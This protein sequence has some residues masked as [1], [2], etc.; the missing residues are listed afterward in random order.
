MMLRDRETGNPLGTKNTGIAC[1]KCGCR[2]FTVVYTRAKDG[3]IV[4]RR[5]CRNCKHRLTTYERA[6]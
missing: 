6:G 4:R 3:V 2:H 5:E 1:R